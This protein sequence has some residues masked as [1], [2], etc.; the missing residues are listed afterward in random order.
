[1]I[2]LSA[3]VPQPDREFF[4]TENVYAIK[5]AVISFVRVCAEKRLPFYF[6]GHPAI[7]P[8]VWNVAKNYY[9]D[10]EP[11]IKIYQ[12]RFFGERIPKEVE[13]F[14]DVHMI[15]AVDNNKSESVNRMRRVMFE[16]N[17]TDSAVF[18]GG[19]DGVVVEA[20]MIRDMYPDARFLPIFS[21]G[22]AAK[23]IYDEFQ[24]NDER[25]KESY[26]FYELFREVL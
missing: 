21:T 6:G 12:S 25:L 13:H 2:F 17:P 19:M 14:K 18:I 3:S 9:G 5:E 24:I 11:A 23:A 10:K 15:D 26:A 22:G 4:G 16:E 8:L 1:M 20:H 7:T